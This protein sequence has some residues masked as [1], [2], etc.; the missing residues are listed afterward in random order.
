[1]PGATA[2]GPSRWSAARI[3]LLV[4][5]VAISWP[6][7]LP[8]GAS[9][10]AVSTVELI[11]ACQPQQGRQKFGCYEDGFLALVKTA[12]A[13]TAMDVLV[14]A[15]AFDRDVQRDGHVFA[16]AIGI[17]AYETLKDPVRAFRHCSEVFQ[18]GCYHGAIQAY[19]EDVLDP[20]LAAD[21]DRLNAVCRPYRENPNSHWL[22]FQCLHAL[23]HGLTGFYDH[24][25]PRALGACDL[26]S[27]EW[28]R[29]SCYGGAFMENVVYGTNTQHPSHFNTH[30]T[31]TRRDPAGSSFVPVKADDPLHPCSVLDERYA[32]DCYQMQTSIIL[33]H[34]HG[35][36]GGAART[37]D[38]APVAMRHA[39][40][41]SLGR[42]IS[43]YTLQQP[44]ESIRLCS[45]GS[46]AYQPWCYVGL[47]KNF[48]DVTA[49]AESGLSF[50]PLVP[51]RANQ[52][53]CYEAIGEELWALMSSDGARAAVCERLDHDARQAC[54]FGARLTDE[55]PQ[56]LPMAEGPHQ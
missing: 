8:A 42:D 17:A 16:H 55:P 3:C 46:P 33:Y 35:D 10:Q 7:A 4:L 21:A 29:H 25:L 45:L 32:A 49:R 40:Y 54:R 56:G 2:T 48:I 43:S 6:A 41:Q 30:P 53:K 51:G 37:C 22:L 23:G 34:N 47:V 52:A 26:L 11:A 19:L 13:G 1:M 31:S 14:V 50:C 24:D 39:C 18:S 9:V 38:G 27:E 28:D 5:V 20:S 15:G 36:I 44:A 12:G